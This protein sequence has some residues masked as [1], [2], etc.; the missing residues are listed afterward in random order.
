MKILQVLHQFLPDHLGGVELYTRNLSKELVR[1]GE[2]VWVLSAPGHVLWDPIERE[3]VLNGLKIIHIIN[4]TDHRRNSF[5]FFKTFKNNSVLKI[6]DR[7]LAEFKPDII[8]F[9]HTVYLSGEM[10]FLAKKRSIPIVLTVHDFWFLCHKLHLLTW[11][12]NQCNGP[13]NVAKCAICLGSENHGIQRWLKYFLYWIPLL[14]RTR[15]Q[16]KVL[17]SVDVLVIPALFIQKILGPYCARQQNRMVH[18]PYGIPYTQSSVQPAKAPYTIRF[19]YLGSVKPHK[20][21]HLLIDAFNSLEG[22][23]STLHIHGNITSDKSNYQELIQQFPKK[24]IF[25][26]GPYDN[27]NVGSILK[28]ID[29]L[30]VPSIWRETGPMVIL[31]AFAAGKPVIAPMLGGMGELIRDG[32][33]GFLFEHGSVSALKKVLRFVLEN[34]S[35]INTLNSRLDNIHSLE[36]NAGKII[37]IYHQLFKRD[38]HAS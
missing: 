6:F 20:G 19:G 4:K 22:N 21:V 17:N 16:I 13:Q 10:V 8:H 12:G 28:D 32:E 35:V 38:F 15:Y 29:V 14:Y 24:R 30:V 3:T 2:E 27:Q 18:I 11:H 33:N 36:S 34:P 26:Y 31:E 9:H 23:K 25:F 7:V 37:E 5:S 1:L